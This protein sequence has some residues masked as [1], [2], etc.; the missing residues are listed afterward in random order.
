MSV[1]NQSTSVTRTSRCLPRTQP[2]TLPSSMPRT[3]IPNYRTSDTSAPR[4]RRIEQHDRVLDGNATNSRGAASRAQHRR[5]T[6]T[7][8][9]ADEV[10]VDTTVSVL[11]TLKCGPRDYGRSRVKT[12]DGYTRTTSTRRLDQRPNKMFKQNDSVPYRYRSSGLCL[13][14]APPRR[15]LNAALYY[16]CSGEWRW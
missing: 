13:F 5:R 15:S 7:A 11:S 2:I 10:A 6:R 12:V 16:A 8:A 14:C 9:G 1:R 3:P 4:T